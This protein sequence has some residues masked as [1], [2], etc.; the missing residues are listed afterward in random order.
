[1]RVQILPDRDLKFFSSEDWEAAWKTAGYAN[2]AFGN[3][4]ENLSKPLSLNSIS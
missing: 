3:N 4:L 2:S 1:M